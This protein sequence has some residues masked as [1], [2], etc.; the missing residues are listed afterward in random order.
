MPPS[1]PVPAPLDVDVDALLDVV[2][3]ALELDPAASSDSLEHDAAASNV[4]DP[5]R[6]ACASIG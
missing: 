4:S 2:A 6:N 5:I 1:P 3:A